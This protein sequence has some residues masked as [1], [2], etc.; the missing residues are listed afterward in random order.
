MKSLSRTFVFVVAMVVAVVAVLSFRAFATSSSQEIPPHKKFKIIKPITCANPGPDGYCQ[1]KTSQEDFDAALNKLSADGGYYRI[2]FLCKTGDHAVEPYHAH[3]PFN[4]SDHPKCH[5][6]TVK[7]TTS[8]VAKNGPAGES[9]A[10]DPNV[11][12][13]LYSDNGTDIQDVLN[14]FK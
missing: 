13:F 7:V 14:K 2:K 8:E 1:L 4:P 6:S 11:T 5:I 12:R 9:V 10:N 3:K